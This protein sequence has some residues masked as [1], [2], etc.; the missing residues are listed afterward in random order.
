M[1][2]TYIRLLVD[3]FDACYSFYA[4]VLGFKA[5]WGKPGEAYASFQVNDATLLSLY[6]R[7]L[8][9]DAL[10]LPMQPKHEANHGFALILEAGDVDAE[11][12]RLKSAGA[13]MIN[14]PKDRLGWGLR[15]FHLT[16]PD[17]NLIEVYKELPKEEWSDDL[18]NH[19]DAENYPEK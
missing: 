5:T 16:D 12:D 3:D 17:G 8:M 4:N 19:P 11:F 7:G 18:K 10:E 15:C 2:M 6:K 13:K 9:L 14:Q 1:K